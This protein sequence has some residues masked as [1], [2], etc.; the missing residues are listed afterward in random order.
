[1]QLGRI[2][3]NIFNMD[4]RLIKMMMR[5]LQEVSKNKYH[6]RNF[7]NQRFPL[8][9]QCYLFLVLTIDYFQGALICV[10]G[11]CNCSLQF[12][13]KDCLWIIRLITAQLQIEILIYGPIWIY[14]AILYIRAYLD[15]W[16]IMD[17]WSNRDIWTVIDIWTNIREYVYIVQCEFKRPLLILV[18][19]NKGGGVCKEC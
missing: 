6:F 13:F 2:D 11:F 8:F 5:T 1:M 12:W 16:T 14:G 7:W 3:T 10:A 9:P 4:F 18:E 19:M 17:I 15:I